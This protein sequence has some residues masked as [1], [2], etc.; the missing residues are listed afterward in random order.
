MPWPHPCISSRNVCRSAADL[1]T[2]RVTIPLRQLSGVDLEPSV[3]ITAAAD[4]A[5]ERVTFR[6]ERACLGDVELDKRFRLTLDAG[7]DV[8]ARQRPNRLFRLGLW[9]RGS[10]DREGGGVA[11]GERA[12]SEG[13]PAEVAAAE[14]SWSCGEGAAGRIGTQ[15]AQRAAL[16]G[17]RH[18]SGVAGG[19]MHAA[20]EA[21]D[22]AP[23]P[24]SADAPDAGGR[25]VLGSE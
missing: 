9:G 17:S 5:N 18:S 6:A 25:Q 12:G 3:A 23:G 4:A 24:Q 19:S 13:G 2:F 22:G 14:A 16:G 15:G 7:L 11:Q 20:V 10:G 1:S 21:L 8:R